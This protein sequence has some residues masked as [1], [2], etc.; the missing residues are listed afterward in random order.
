MDRLRRILIAAIVFSLL[1]VFSAAAEIAQ[2][3]PAQQRARWRPGPIKIAIS[4][5]L[6]QPE[7]NIKWNSDV[8]AAIERAIDAWRNVA[9]VEFVQVVSDKLSV[10]PVGTSG[11]GVSLITIAPTAENVLIFKNDPES[12]AKTRV[13]V[14]RRG[15]ISEADIILSPFQQFSTDGSY[16]SFDLETTIKHEI[17][18]LLGLQHSSVVGSVMYEVTSKNGVFGETN[19]RA[20]KLTA[21][22]LSAIRDLYD[23]GVYTGCCGVLSGRLTGFNKNTRSVELW[24]QEASTGRIVAHAAASDEGEFRFG[25]IGAGD[26]DVI[27]REVGKAGTMSTTSLGEA[28]VKNAETT[29]FDRTIAHRTLDFSTELLG[30]N[31]I[32][33]DSPLKLSRG[34][35]YGLYIGGR[36]LG[37]GHIKLDINSPHLTIDGDSLID[38]DYDE[39]ISGLKFS[40]KIDA[41]TPPGNYSICAISP[42][43]ARDCIAGGIVVLSE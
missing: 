22:D 31:G 32:L 9:D 4:Q 6:L 41:E 33:S 19:G 18:H 11:D 1:A 2:P 42:S 34:T 39:G 25:G 8:R 30:K 35:S 28:T 12:A 27:A 17:G 43:G 38:M 13:F 20:G 7:P 21:D 40:L 24:L 5:S 26:Y 3:S 29:S 37:S 14:N 16:G 15:F 23:D 36:Q 10:S